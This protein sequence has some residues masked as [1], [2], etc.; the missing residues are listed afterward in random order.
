MSHLQTFQ[1]FPA[2]PEPL[3]F[4]E[5]LCRNYWWSWQRDAVDLFRRIDPR[6]WEEAGRNPI[7]FSTYI[8]QDRLEELSRDESFLAHQQ[9]V[10]E[11]YEKRVLNP[12]NQT[13][14]QFGQND[15]IAYFSMEFG[16]HESLPLYSGGLGM[17]A[18]DHLKAAS[19]LGLPLIGV[20]IFIGRVTFTSTWILKACSRRSIRKPIFITFRCHGP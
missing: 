9:R 14:F 3:L 15:W 2:T 20:G 17:L 16:I 12:L 7:V 4:L 18:G 19:N 8:S 13:N 10:K 11:R 6:L 1:V 5:E